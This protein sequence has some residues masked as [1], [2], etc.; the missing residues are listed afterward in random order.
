MVNQK[1]KILWNQRIQS[2]YYRIGFESSDISNHAL[3]GQFV[4]V[5]ISHHGAPLLRRP[6]SI[7]RLIKKNG[8]KIGFELLY[9]IVGQGTQIMA[10]LKN[11][12]ELDIIG[13]LGNGF[14]VPNMITKAVIV[15]GGMGVAPMIFLGD[16]VIE[17]RIKTDHYIGAKTNEDILCL[18]ELSHMGIVSEV[19]TDDGSLGQKGFVSELL[20]EGISKEKP[21]IIFSCGPNPMLKAI[22]G[23]AKKNQI[24]CQISLETHMACGMGAC[25]GCAIKRPDFS[26][27]FLHTCIEG[28]VVYTDQVDITQL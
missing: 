17:K 21:D 5:R 4:M 8:K 1:S 20:M 13:P 27:G 9:K 2:K 18:N 7:H 28:P 16:W 10:Q 22:A 11:N 14:Q 15:S 24:P 12:D 23:I 25:L 26:N 19:A 6:F 3:P